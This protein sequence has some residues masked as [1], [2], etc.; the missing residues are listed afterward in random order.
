MEGWNAANSE[1]VQLTETEKKRQEIIN[2]ESRKILIHRKYFKHR[3]NR[4]RTFR[5]G[6]ES[7]EDLEDLAQRVHA[8]AWGEQ[9]NVIGAYPDGVS[10]VP[11]CPEGMA[12]SI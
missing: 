11:A 1:M 10:T 9:S 6:K 5:D 8:S 7:R 3:I 12:Q 4:L 2:G